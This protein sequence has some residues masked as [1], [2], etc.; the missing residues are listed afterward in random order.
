MSAVW[1]RLRVEARARWRAWLFLAVLIGVLAGA[2]IAA[3]AGARRT[4]SAYPRFLKAFAGEDVSVSVEGFPDGARTLSEIERIPQVR[5]MARYA[6]V[7]IEAHVSTREVIGFPQIFGVLSLDANQGAVVNRWKMLSGRRPAPDR[8]DEIAVH[9]TLADRFV[10][11]LTRGLAESEPLEMQILPYVGA[12]RPLAKIRMRVVGVYAMPG[13]FETLTG[14][15][16]PVVMIPAALARRFPQLTVPTDASIRLRRGAADVPAFA[17]AMRR[18]APEL[19]APLTPATH[20]AGVQK[21]NASFATTLWLIGAA[22]AVTALGIC[23]QMLG[24]ENWVL[25][26]DH[27]VLRALGMSRRQLVA[28]SLARVGAIAAAA[29]AIAVGVAVLISPL[30]PIGAAKYAEPH[31][32]IAADVT[33]LA[34]GATTTVFLFLGVTSLSVWRSANIPPALGA[35]QDEGAARSGVASIA[36]R[37]GVRPSILSGVRFALERGRGRTSVPVRAAL[38]TAALAV[39]AP[40]A[41]TIFTQSFDHIGPEGLGYT[42]DAIVALEPPKVDAAARRLRA[43]PR[44]ATVSRGSIFSE[45]EVDELGLEAVVVEPP[46]RVALVDGRLPEAPDEVALDPRSLRDLGLAIGDRVDVRQTGSGSAGVATGAE[47]GAPVSMKV[48]GTFV[49]GR[50]VFQGERPSQGVALTPGAMRRVSPGFAFDA[51]YVRVR[52]P[53]E[54]G[55]IPGVKLEGGG[56][57]ET[58]RRETGSALISPV[59]GP[60]E[61]VS[62]ASPLG[63]LTTG[64]AG[65]VAVVGAATIAYTL[66]TSVTRRRRDLAILKTLGF[67][68]RQVRRAVKWQATTMA[69]LALAV[70]VPLGLG[71]GQWSFRAYAGSLGIRPTPYVSPWA[72]G[73]GI[74]LLTL[75]VSRLAAGI[76]GRFAARTRPALILRAE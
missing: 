72:A 64:L 35:T 32:G 12:S 19:G 37:A 69:L 74:P 20:V 24:R 13:Q 30:T 27:P 43:D 16:F 14:N 51:L 55:G 63:G 18:V 29:G 21:S 38:V 15:S 2:A 75:I 57:Y 70:G 34:L 76:P 4:A 42:W 48:I 1:V 39:A 17:A 28:L 47:P 23:G 40:V 33:V 3:G 68:R 9:F 8:I 60:G 26:G 41:A 52:S 11:D 25:A 7:S 44:I 49:K 22:V 73:I 58:L 61:F 50:L 6:F 5:T 71:G 67:T 56:L 10:A 66:F 54:F 36:A 46:I 62:I 65:L 59:R 31:P 45:L 53:D